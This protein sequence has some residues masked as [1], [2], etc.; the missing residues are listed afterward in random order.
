VCVLLVSWRQRNDFRL[1][2]AANRDEAYARPARRPE[3]V[4]AGNARALAPRDL[5]AGGTWIGVASTGLVVAI[6]NRRDGDADA[7]RPSRGHLCRLALEQPDAAAV[8]RFLIAETRA[9]TYN[10]FNLL[11]ADREQAWVTSWNGTLRI[12]ELHPGVAVLSNDHALGEVAPPALAALQDDGGAV[13]RLRETLQSFAARHDPEP[14]SGLVICKHGA[15]HGTVSSSLVF[16]P[17]SA[18]AWIEYAAGPPCRAGFEIHALP[19]T[20]RVS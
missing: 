5:A 14:E 7:S 2:L 11:H 3:N 9:R 17:A 6:T 16:L 10:S 8:R 15:T 18:P 1:V 4:R 13:E 12:T 20:A 19:S